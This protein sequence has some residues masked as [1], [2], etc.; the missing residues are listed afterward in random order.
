MMIED[1][2]IPWVNDV[3]DTMLIMGPGEFY[4]FLFPLMYGIV[5]ALTQK[6]S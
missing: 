5:N 4:F 1:Q 6:K 3:T 2:G